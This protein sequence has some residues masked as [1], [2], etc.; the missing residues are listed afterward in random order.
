MTE[1]PSLWQRFWRSPWSAVLFVFVF[2]SLALSDSGWWKWLNVAIA[3]YWACRFM[4]L[5]DKRWGKP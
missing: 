1:E 5:A 2:G 4:Q 3:A